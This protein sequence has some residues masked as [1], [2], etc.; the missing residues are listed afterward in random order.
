MFLLASDGVWAAMTEYELTPP[1]VGTGAR[2][3]AMRNATAQALV[4]AALAAG[5]SDNASALVLKVEAL[6]EASLRDA[7]VR[8]AASCRCRRG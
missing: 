6:P 7:R 5:S 3:V 8:L 1:L 2:R 4:E